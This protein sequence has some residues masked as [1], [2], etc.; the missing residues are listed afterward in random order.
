MNEPAPGYC[1]KSALDRLA[2]LSG[3]MLLAPLALGIAAA[4]W[5]EDGGPP[6]FRQVRVG[7]QRRPFT[8]LKFRTYSNG[9][10]TH[11]GGLLRRTGLDELPQFLNVWRGEMSVVGPRPLTAADID[12]LQWS[13]LEWRFAMKP[14]ITGIAQLFG[15]RDAKHSRRLDRLYLRRQS[16]PLDARLIAL[17]GVVNLLGKR[18]VRRWLRRFAL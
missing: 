5:L 7:A 9:R 14:G 4:T 11:V 16:L 2:A 3:C 13:G 10:V 8:V 6:L 12:R 15:G 1:G 17:S 18:R